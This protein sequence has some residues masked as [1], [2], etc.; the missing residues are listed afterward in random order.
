MRGGRPPCTW[1]LV[2]VLLV[3]LGEREVEGECVD[4]LPNCHEMADA[5]FDGK[6]VPKLSE[7]DC[8]KTCSLEKHKRESSKKEAPVCVERCTEH[9]RG[10]RG[11]VTKLLDLGAHDHT[12]CVDACVEG[13]QNCALCVEELLASWTDGE[14]GD[15]HE[16][17]NGYAGE[18][19]P[20]DDVQKHHELAD[21]PPAC[22]EKCIDQGRGCRG[23]VTKLVDAGAADDGSCVSA[24]VKEKR[25]C[26]D[27][28]AYLK[29]TAW[30]V[31]HTVPAGSVSQ[32]WTGV[33]STV[34][35]CVCVGGG[36]DR[37]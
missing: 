4:V 20:S 24:C 16:D 34:S 31:V 2:L 32:P 1:L 27:C 9:G 36:A 17:E 30:C 5:C 23:C 35:R 25:G 19:K 29:D 11:C 37:A 14:D 15:D 6:H 26:A 12:Y 28:V 22:A 7:V 8:C 33:R 21:A 10:C 13:A 18:E 3:L